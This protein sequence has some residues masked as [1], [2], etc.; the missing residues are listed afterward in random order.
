MESMATSR[1]G[2]GRPRGFRAGIGIG[3]AVALLGAAVGTATGAVTPFQQVIIRN[4]PTEPVPVTGTINVGNTPANQNVSVTN[5]PSTQTVSVSNFPATQPV[6]GTVNVANAPAA[7]Q[8]FYGSASG[9]G[10]M[11]FPFGKT[12]NITA[13]FI[14]DGTGDNY[15]VFVDGYHIAENV[16]D[17][18][19][20]QFAYPIP[21]TG[22]QVTCLN[23]TL[24]C[25]PEVIVFGF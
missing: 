17:N 3:L 4:G 5:F 16:E 19:S 11:A 21:A 15:D 8:K 20:V 6:S 24:D 7:A 13:L 10:D 23:L 18:Y 2:A 22:V 1:F 9:D 12:I 14:V 25:H